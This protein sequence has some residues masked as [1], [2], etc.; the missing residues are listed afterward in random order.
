M[1]PG[2]FAVRGGIIDV[3]PPGRD[4]PVRLDFF[5]DEL[6]TAR[7]FDTVSQRSSDDVKSFD[8]IPVSEIL[9]ND[10]SIS[11]FRSGYRGLFGAVEGED[12]LYEAVSSGRRMMGMEHWLGLF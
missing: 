2:E 9:L 3:F 10:D 4:L 12:P 7:A 1:E 11:R 8:L 6:E 5:G